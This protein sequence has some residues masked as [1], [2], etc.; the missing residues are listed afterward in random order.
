MNFPYKGTRNPFHVWED[1][2]FI[3]QLTCGSFLKCDVAYY[4]QVLAILFHM[5]KYMWFTTI[6]M[7]DS[8][9]KCIT[10]TQIM[11][12]IMMTLIAVKYLTLAK[13][14]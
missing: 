4:V 9:L 11:S 14:L 3:V 5:E 6:L 12:C 13:L 8:F 10:P 2:W 1:M 7:S